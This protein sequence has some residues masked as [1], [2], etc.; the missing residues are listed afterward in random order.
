[1]SLMSSYLMTSKNLEAFLN[2][3]QGAK[4]PDRFTNKFL[5]DLDFKSTNDRLFIGV[6]KG[7][8]FIDDAGVPLDRYFAYLDQGTSAVVLAD[9]IREAYSD[10]FAINT[11]AHQLSE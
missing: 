4:A 11:N 1:M 5:T 7:L 2:A 6:L 10:L 9:A 8:G 3:I